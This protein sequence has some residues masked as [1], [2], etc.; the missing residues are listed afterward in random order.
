[1]GRGRFVSRG[2]SDGVKDRLDDVTQQDTSL[3]SLDYLRLLYEEQ[4]KTN[5]YL[6]EMLGDTL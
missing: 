3:T 5:L 6:A 4:K 2:D 1:M